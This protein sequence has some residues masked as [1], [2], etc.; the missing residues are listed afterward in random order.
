M[1]TYKG[2]KGL[3]IQTVAGDPSVLAAGD[4]WYD[5]V[6]R[7]VQGAATAVGAW[8]SGGNMPG[9]A[10]TNTGFGTLSTFT[11]TK[12]NAVSIDKSW[13]SSSTA[14]SELLP[15]LRD[16]L[17]VNAGSSEMIVDVADGFGD[18]SAPWGAATVKATYDA[19]LE[20]FVPIPLETGFVSGYQSSLDDLLLYEVSL[21]T[22]AVADLYRSYPRAVRPSVRPDG[23]IMCDQISTT[24][25]ST[26][27]FATINFRCQSTS[28]VK[29]IV[30]DSVATKLQIQHLQVFAQEGKTLLEL[31]I[32]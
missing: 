7:K 12:H 3:S 2:I 11:F 4:I 14:S 8:A 22:S 27:A 6:A 32:L 24:A 30:V 13:G 20:G 28:P 18:M 5:S 26:T 16:L 31:A 23:H 1:T 17:A 9:P 25:P 21:N 19:S 10:S 29:Y 15:P